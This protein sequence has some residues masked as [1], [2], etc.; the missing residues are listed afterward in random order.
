MHVDPGRIGVA[1]GDEPG[2]DEIRSTAKYG[3][4]IDSHAEVHCRN[5]TRLA[6]RV[7]FH[8][9]ATVIVSLATT[10]ALRVAETWNCRRERRHLTFRHV[11]QQLPGRNRLREGTNMANTLT[12]T[13]LSEAGFATVNPS[14]GEEIEA[15]S[16]FTPG[17]IETVV[18]RAD[19]SFRAFRKL[20]VHRRARLLADLAGALRKN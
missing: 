3:R 7:I 9:P 4:G 19:E 5:H 8:D 2:A 13:R 11:G 1:S 18:A 6:T 14:T 10:H 17:Q 15:F 16:F 20:S 12:R